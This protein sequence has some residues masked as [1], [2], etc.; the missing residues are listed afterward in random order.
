MWKTSQFT[1]VYSYVIGN[2][3]KWPT[4]S[5]D[6]VIFCNLF[7]LFRVHTLPRV[8][9]MVMGKHT[10]LTWSKLAQSVHVLGYFW[11]VGEHSRSHSSWNLRIKPSTLE[12]QYDVET[13]RPTIPTTF[14]FGHIGPTTH[15]GPFHAWDTLSQRLNCGHGQMSR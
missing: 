7:I 4:T 2:Q 9:V 12:L 10:N 3:G 13:L 5:F 11:E 1:E 14:K 8:R 6:S 15:T